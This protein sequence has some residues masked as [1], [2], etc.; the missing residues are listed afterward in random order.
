MRWTRGH[1]SEDV[2]LRGSS[3]GRGGLPMGLLS[4]VGSRFGVL[5]LVV[6]VGGYFLMQYFSGS[7][8]SQLGGGSSQPTD[9]RSDEQVQFVSFVLDDAQNTWRNLFAQKDRRYEKARLV[10]YRDTTQTGC[11]FG[12]A[13]A[14]PFYC[15]NDG[16]VYIDLSFYDELQKK[17]GAPGDFAQAY[18]IAHEIGHHV[19]NQLGLL[20]EN[21]DSGRNSIS[22]RQELQADCLAGIWAHSAQARNLL[23]IGDV[24]EALGAAAAIGDDTLQRKSEGVVRPESWTHGSAAERTRWF[25]VGLERGRIED[26]D[27]GT[28]AL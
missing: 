1:Q 18:V 14:G 26:C 28:T 16:I 20:R 6:L 3:G 17:F 10:I 2:E 4:M 22:V 23:E 5:G 19:Q 15:P 24:D 12:T 13:A 21:R 7:S 25:K 11:G 9:Q 27:T 8:P